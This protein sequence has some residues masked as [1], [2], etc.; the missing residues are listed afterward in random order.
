V[1]VDGAASDRHRGRP[2][3]GPAQRRLRQSGA[4]TCGKDDGRQKT[5][6]PDR[7]PPQVCW[8]AETS[9]AFFALCVACSSE[10][11]PRVTPIS[12]A[13]TRR[14]IK[15]VTGSEKRFMVDQQWL[16]AAADRNRPGYIPLAKVFLRR[17]PPAM[18]GS[19][20]GVVS[21]RAR[22]A[23]KAAWMAAVVM[24]P[25]ARVAIS[26]TNKGSRSG[27]R[28]I[29]VGVPNRAAERPKP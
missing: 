20:E 5:I 6:P 9:P 15:A 26:L 4:I 28:R 17:S 18:I 25:L 23:F 21:C 24:M 13:T 14:S 12:V 1:L 27:N 2:A 19:L 7:C 29:L 22:P 16:I 3:P 11:K 10:H 8:R